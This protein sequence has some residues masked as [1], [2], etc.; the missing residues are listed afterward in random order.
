MTSV[1]LPLIL[2]GIVLLAVQAWTL[3]RILEDVRKPQL[4]FLP[5]D[6]DEDGGQ[7]EEPEPVP[8]D[9]ETIC[10][11][12]DRL[13][14]SS[15]HVRLADAPVTSDFRPAHQ[16]LVEQAFPCPYDDDTAQ[17]LDRGHHEIDGRHEWRDR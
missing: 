10:G 5:V 8:S 15:P 3:L 17:V 1:Y 4:V 6:D 12:L 9:P 14:P 2:A 16:R 7:G 13:Q 11:A